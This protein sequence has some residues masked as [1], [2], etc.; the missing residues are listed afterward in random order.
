M[1]LSTRATDTPS[2]N[3]SDRPANGRRSP[4]C[5]HWWPRGGATKPVNRASSTAADLRF[6]KVS[7]IRWNA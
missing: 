4:V 6:T 3:C 2:D 5:G 7:G 1:S